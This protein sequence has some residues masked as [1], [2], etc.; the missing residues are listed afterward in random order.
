MVETLPGVTLSDVTLPG[1]TLLAVTQSSVTVKTPI[2]GVRVQIVAMVW[3][4]GA[5]TAVLVI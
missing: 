4:Q 3:R 1:V 5:G 2:G